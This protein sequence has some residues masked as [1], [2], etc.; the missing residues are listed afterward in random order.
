MSFSNG[1]LEKVNLNNEELQKLLTKMSS[2]EQKELADTLKACTREVT[3]TRGLPITAA[4]IGSLY[5]A[6]T[7]LPPQYHFGPKGWPF[8]AIMGIGCLTT[9]NV[10]SMG[11]CRD[12]I[13]PFIAKMW[14]KYNVGHSSTSYD[15]IRRRHR[16]E[17]GFAASDVPQAGVQPRKFEDPYAAADQ[18]DRDPY[19]RGVK[20]PS[21]GEMATDY[22]KMGN[23]F[24]M[25]TN[26][27]SSGQYSKPMPS[28]A[29][30][31]DDTPSYMSGT[32]TTRSSPSEFS[33]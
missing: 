26:D 11:Q 28:P 31:Y 10:F 4:L 19:A 6:R 24:D 9:V 7:R 30:M 5:Y 14:Q 16:Q 23:T 3:L 18:S 33:R 13:Q 17:S 8:Y 25:T 20:V 21:F 1:N 32:P 27:T 2:D 29:Y 22:T 12:R 15:D